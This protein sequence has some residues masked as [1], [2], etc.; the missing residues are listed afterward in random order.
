MLVVVR[1]GKQEDGKRVSTT[2][3]VDNKNG[4]SG[5]KEEEDYCCGI[6]KQNKKRDS[7]VTNGES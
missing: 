2:S 3:P 1:R 5:C 6:K 7:L 4:W